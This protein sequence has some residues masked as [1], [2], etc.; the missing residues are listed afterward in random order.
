MKKFITIIL[1]ASISAAAFAQG[2][3]PGR[4]NGPKH[5]GKAPAHHNFDSEKIGRLTAAMDLTPEEAQ[6]FWP[7]YNKVEA[8]QKELAKAEFEAFKALDNALMNGEGD[9]DALLEA[10]AKAKKA[11][12]DQHIAALKDYKKVLPAEKV[13]L[14]YKANGHHCGHMNHGFKPAPAKEMPAN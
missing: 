4:I 11:N 13:A 6:A 3:N 2:G 14:F 9:I 1:L 5:Y 8:K 10:Y 7:V 12:T